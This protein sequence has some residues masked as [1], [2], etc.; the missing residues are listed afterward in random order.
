MRWSAEHF[1]KQHMTPTEKGAS[2][3]S[4]LMQLLLSRMESMEAAMRDIARKVT[5]PGKIW[6][7]PCEFAALMGVTT[8]TIR[9]WVAKGRFSERSHRVHITSGGKKINQFHSVHASAEVGGGQ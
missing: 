4:V 3:S 8:Q 5:P 2:E 9:E 7:D 6:M 1:F